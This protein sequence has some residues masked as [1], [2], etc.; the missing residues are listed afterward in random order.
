MRFRLKIGF[1]DLKH[2]VNLELRTLGAGVPL[3]RQG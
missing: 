1:D 3:A 2:P